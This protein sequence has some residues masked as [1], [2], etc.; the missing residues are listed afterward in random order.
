MSPLVERLGRRARA[1][2]LPRGSP[3]QAAA[4]IA[5]GPAHWIC[6]SYGGLV[7]R[8][9][10]PER[11]RSL[12]LVATLPDPSLAPR[13]IVWKSRML[14]HLPA[15]MVERAYDR[16]TR[17]AL[18]LDGVEDHGVRLDKATLVERLRGA[19]APVPMPR[20][21][22]LWVLGSHDPF[23]RWSTAEIQHFCPW[24]QVV[25]VPGGH[26]PWATHTEAF[27]AVVLPFVEAALRGGG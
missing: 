5:E 16:H 19:L 21:P 22:T 7:A 24:A 6:G 8:S 25:H 26:R 4:R 12:V 9:L 10:P 17:R 14:E 13:D 2:D 18:E 27:L 20:V 15:A 11:V 23:A 3:A 1:L